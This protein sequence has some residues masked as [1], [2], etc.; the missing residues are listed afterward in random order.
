ML[1]DV[2]PTDPITYAAMAGL[3]MVVT[4]LA[5]LKPAHRATHV[6]PRIALRHERLPAAVE[7]GWK[8]VSAAPGEDYSEF[9]TLTVSPLE[10]DILPERRHAWVT[11]LPKKAKTAWNCCKLLEPFC[12]CAYCPHFWRH[13]FA[14]YFQPDSSLPNR[15]LSSR[16]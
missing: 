1:F 4:L 9:T 13:R 12:V 14:L 10:V 15:P 5:C 11:C 3:L 8:P 2:N 6:D 7:F 16:W